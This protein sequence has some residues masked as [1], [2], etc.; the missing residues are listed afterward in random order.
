[1]WRLPRRPAAQPQPG[2]TD[3]DSLLGLFPEFLPWVCSS[4]VL[5]PVLHAASATDNGHHR[6]DDESPGLVVDVLYLTW[7]GEL[8]TVGTEAAQDPAC[9][10]WSVVSGSFLSEVRGLCCRPLLLAVEWQALCWGQ[11]WASV[12]RRPW[13][14]GLGCFEVCWAGP[15]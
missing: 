7:R 10:A 2:E 3:E 15:F 13:P 12:P 11:D 4:E 1:M 5:V 14:Q 6:P 8:C 9:T